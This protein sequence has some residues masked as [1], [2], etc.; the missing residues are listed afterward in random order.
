MQVLSLVV[1]DARVGSPSAEADG[2]KAFCNTLLPQFGRISCAVQRK[3]ETPYRVGR[4][5]RILA[6]NLDIEFSGRCC[7]E[8]S[9]PRG[10]HTGAPPLFSVFVFRCCETTHKVHSAP[11]SRRSM[12]DVMVTVNISMCTLTE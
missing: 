9:S 8:V 11:G 10:H 4:P 6:K 1:E 3:V 12:C 5:C 2:D 7:M